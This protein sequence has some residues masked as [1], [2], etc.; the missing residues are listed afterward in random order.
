MLEGGLFRDVCVFLNRVLFIIYIY[1]YNSVVTFCFQNPCTEE[2]EL[3]LR[4]THT[5]THTHTNG[6]GGFPTPFYR[7]CQSV[8]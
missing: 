1:I 4:G 2:R 7:C 8:Y 3:G 6:N 5:H